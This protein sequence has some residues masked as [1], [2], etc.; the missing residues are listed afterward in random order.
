M[1]L[2]HHGRILKGLLH[3]ILFIVTL[4]IRLPFLYFVDNNGR[5]LIDLKDKK[6]INYVV[7][8][9]EQN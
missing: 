1:D 3:S 4:A 7:M 2:Y 5:K 9:R 6:T 8:T